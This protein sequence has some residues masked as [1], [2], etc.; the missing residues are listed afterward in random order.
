MFALS[1]ISLWLTLYAHNP[2]WTLRSTP[3]RV[4]AVLT[5]S[6]EA[7]KDYGPAYEFDIVVSNRGIRISLHT[8]LIAVDNLEDALHVLRSTI[9][10]RPPYL[11]VGSECGGSNDWACN[12]ESVLMFK[13]G[14]LSVFGEFVVNEDRMAAMSYHDGKFR[15]VYDKLQQ[16]VFYLSLADSPFLGIVFSD[17]GGKPRVDPDLTWQENQRDYLESLR[18]ITTIRPSD[19]D[20][21]LDIYRSLVECAVLAKYCGRN[22][23]LSRLKTLAFLVLTANQ[24]AGLEDALSRVSPGESPSAWREQR[25]TNS[26]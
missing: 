19:S 2:S 5:K 23:E 3:V 7:S 18:K 21:L 26:H 12:R 25:V 13:G 16:G 22:E 8:F 20:E 9:A 14:A 10:W 4:E 15:D 6:Y 1:F 24:Q 17:D 11:F